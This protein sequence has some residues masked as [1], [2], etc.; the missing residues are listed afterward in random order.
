VN[1]R[2]GFM[3]VF[4]PAHVVERD[5]DL[6]VD[7]HRFDVESGRVETE[8]W[9]V[10]GGAVRKTVFSVRFYAFNELRDLLLG[11]GFGSV[12]AFARDGGPLTADSRRMVVVATR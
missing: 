12:S 11:A 2:D 9:S 7:R 6:L 5:G 10:R 1:S 3:R 8:R 4:V